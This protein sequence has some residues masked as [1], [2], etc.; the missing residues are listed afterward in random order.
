VADNFK[1]LWNS[2][3]EVTNKTLERNKDRPVLRLLNTTVK[4][5][6]G[7]LKAIDVFL[8][9]KNIDVGKLYESSKDKGKSLLDKSKTFIENTKKTGLKATSID[10]R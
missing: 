2:F 8:K 3:R 4:S 6:E 9:E 7:I 1:E 5:L 10:I